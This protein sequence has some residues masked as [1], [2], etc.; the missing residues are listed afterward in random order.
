MATCRTPEEAFAAGQADSA[1]DP[2]LTQ[3]KADLIAVILG[4]HRKTGRRPCA[5]IGVPA[6]LLD[7]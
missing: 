7:M 4:R 5:P 2:P 1:N 6:R 3:E